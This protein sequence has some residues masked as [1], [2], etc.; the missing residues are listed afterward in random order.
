VCVYSCKVIRRLSTCRSPM[1][2]TSAGLALGL[3]FAASAAHAQSRF[4]RPIAL[5]EAV[6]PVCYDAEGSATTLEV[7]RFL[8]ARA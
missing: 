1:R 8:A 2:C 6:E 3:V 5:T 4:V 7:T